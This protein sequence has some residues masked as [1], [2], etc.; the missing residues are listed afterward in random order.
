[1]D[2][3][4]PAAF[5]SRVSLYSVPLATAAP[6]SAPLCA[7]WLSDFWGETEFQL[8]AK[9][10]SPGGRRAHYFS[11]TSFLDF[12]SLSLPLATWSYS[13]HFICRK[14]LH[15]YNSLRD[16]YCLCPDCRP[17]NPQVQ[18]CQ[19]LSGPSEWWPAEGTAGSSTLSAP[20][21]TQQPG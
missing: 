4:G 17:G 1:M 21:W 13:K 7:S 15:S 20:P 9:C 5:V 14:A 3:R 6:F 18:K 16:G 19:G 11:S 12:R 10:G 2:N 8:Y